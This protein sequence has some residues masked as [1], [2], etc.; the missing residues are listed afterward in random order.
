MRI[1]NEE[2]VISIIPQVLFEDWNTV[3]FCLPFSENNDFYDKSE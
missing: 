1:S 3:A 2:N